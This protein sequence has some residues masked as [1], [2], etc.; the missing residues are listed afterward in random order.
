MDTWVAGLTSTLDHEGQ[1]EVE[2]LLEGLPE[3]T[4][5]DLEELAQLEETIEWQ[6]LDFAEE[7]AIAIADNELLSNL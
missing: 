5:Q 1:Y 2:D 3:L 6:Q 7:A 4:I